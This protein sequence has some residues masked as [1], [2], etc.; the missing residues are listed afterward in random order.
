MAVVSKV[1]ELGSL[2][3]LKEDVVSVGMGMGV[4]GAEHPI[5][6]SANL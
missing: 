3:G 6:K 1:W 4:L 5:S 2:N